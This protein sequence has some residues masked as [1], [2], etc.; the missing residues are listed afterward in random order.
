MEDV[1]RGRGDG[2]KECSSR[3]E[4]I[5]FYTPVGENETDYQERESR[6]G[7]NVYMLVIR[8]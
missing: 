3:G 8:F 2:E 7:L 5:F 4:E 1:G 6:M